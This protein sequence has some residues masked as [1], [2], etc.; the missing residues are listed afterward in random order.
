MPEINI[1][2]MA[3]IVVLLLFIASIVAITIRR[4]KMPYTVALVIVG[5]SAAVLIQESQ[6]QLF[7]SEQLQWFLAPEVILALLVPPLI[8]EAAS[9]IK[10][11]E[12]GR[13]LK[14]ILTFAIPGVILT[15]FL[16]GGLI[17]WAGAPLSWEMAL[18]FG[19]LI[20]ATDPVAVVALFRS[21]GVPKQ[22]QILL[23]GESLFNDGTAIVVYNLMLL[24]ALGVQDFSLS[25][26]IFDF[27][28]VAGGGLLIGAILSGVISSIINRIDD[29]LIEITLTAIAAYGSYLMAE[30]FHTSGVL[31]VVAAGLVTGNIGKRSMSPTTRIALNSFWEFAAFLTNSLIFLMIGL[32]IDLQIMFENWQFILIA[33]AAV[34]IARAVTIYSFSNIK[35]Q[36]PIRVQHVLYW[37]GLRGA[38]S[39]ALALGLPHTIEAIMSTN[40]GIDESLLEMAKLIQVM[41]YGVVLFSLLV[42]GTT[43]QALVKKLKL[44]QRSPTQDAYELNQARAVASKASFDHLKKLNNEGLISQHAWEL[45]ENPMRRVIENRRKAVREIL[46]QD[47]N[48]EVA[49]FSLA[50]EEALRA[51]RS[52]YNRLLSS[53]A[54]SEDSFSQLVSEVDHALLNREFSFGDFLVQR[55]ADS[56]PITDLICATVS[57][58]D[59]GGT[60]TT[61]NIMGIPTT[62][63]HSISGN[64]DL[65][66][67]TLLIGVEKDQ[68]EEVIQAI[69]SCCTT[70]PTFD[71]SFLK[72]FSSKNKEE[73]YL[74][75]MTIFSIQ[76]EKYEEF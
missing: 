29:H 5:L 16:V 10:F 17:Y 50:Y 13:Y 28:R 67:T 34:L 15:M 40:P 24:I 68:V 22:L 38:I 32:I 51:Q 42:Q 73:I 65:P 49:E 58:N 23:E 30:S 43:M 53:G 2:Q 64:D 46:R 19:A 72:F 37:G 55:S 63:L 26:T 71:S 18:V 47:R 8:Y 60:L 54:L 4:F 76:V 33:I 7:N 14:I 57:E 75:G 9:H 1:E 20:A 52:T 41:A 66:L 45:I 25:S 44:I 61:L 27:L 74:N 48:V 11:S 31:A 12:L 35:R 62:Q 59:L 69:S 70:E 39:L 36:I 21:M 56:L 3:E 6:D